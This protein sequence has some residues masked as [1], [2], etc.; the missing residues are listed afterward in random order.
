[1]PHSF[2]VEST[3][4]QTREC[5][6][7]A[8]LCA[9]DPGTMKT[10]TIMVVGSPGVVRDGYQALFSAIAGVRALEPADDGPSALKRLAS[11]TPDVVILDA[12]ANTDHT[13]TILSTIR[14]T[15]HQA[16]CL[17]ICSDAVQ[18]EAVSDCGADVAVLEGILPVELAA[19]VKQ[20]AHDDHPT[21]DVRH[22]DPPPV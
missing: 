21:E 3:F 7:L 18:T 4:L 6:V 19:Q 5:G 11:E 8:I 10:I 14:R 13:M 12:S 20:M 15:G 2:T 9:R 16:R 1:M 22:L 17:V